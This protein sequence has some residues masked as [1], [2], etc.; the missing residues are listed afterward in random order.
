MVVS[1]GI[2]V[3]ALVDPFSWMPPLAEVWADCRDDRDT[4][5]DECDLAARF[6]GFWVHVGVNLGWAAVAAFWVLASFAAAFWLR[7]ERAARFDDEAAWE[8]YDQ[9]RLALASCAGSTLVVAA[10]PIVVAAL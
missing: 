8:R 6:P 7:D 2:S 5:A 3:A 1:A 4:A 9:A 10:I